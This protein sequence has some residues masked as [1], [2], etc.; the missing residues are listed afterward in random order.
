MGDPTKELSAEL[1]TLLPTSIRPQ[2]YTYP[3]R[4]AL[5]RARIISMWKTPTQL[6]I[7]PRAL[8]MRV[9]QSDACNRRLGVVADIGQTLNS[10]ITYQHL[11]DDKPDVRSCPHR[12][13]CMHSP[14][15]LACP[16]RTCLHA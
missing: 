15:A 16:M 5:H 11:V 12:T 10:S 9:S 4:C 13:C 2:T 1:K 6:H 8:S 14:R 7:C 3:M